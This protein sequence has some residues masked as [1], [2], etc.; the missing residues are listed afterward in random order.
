VLFKKSSCVNVR[1][2]S[3]CAENSFNQRQIV[4]LLIADYIQSLS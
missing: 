2:E 4:S 3:K 1:K